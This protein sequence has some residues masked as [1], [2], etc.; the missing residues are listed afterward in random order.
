MKTLPDVRSLQQA[1]TKVLL[2]KGA[3]HPAIH[4]Y[5]NFEFLTCGHDR[6]K[7]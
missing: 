1:L 6:A 3:I 4:K 2:L 5:I 7:M